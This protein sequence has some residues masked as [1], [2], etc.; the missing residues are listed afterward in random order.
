MPETRLAIDIG[1]TFTDVVLEMDGRHVTTK[2][3][4]TSRAPEQG[5]MEGFEKIRALSGVDPGDIRLVIHGTTLATN[6]LRATAP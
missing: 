2:V 5:V 3:L 4:T 1:G 6:A